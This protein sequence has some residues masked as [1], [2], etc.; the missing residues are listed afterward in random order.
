M[1]SRSQCSIFSACE[2]EMSSKIE[3]LRSDSPLMRLVRSIQIFAP[4]NAFGEE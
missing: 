1:F 2:V 3:V 4:E